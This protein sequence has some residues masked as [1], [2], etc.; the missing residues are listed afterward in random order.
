M[1]NVSK[2]DVHSFTSTSRF[3]HRFNT[4]IYKHR[5]SLYFLV[6]GI[7][8][9]VTFLGLKDS[10]MGKENPNTP[11]NNISTFSDPYGPIQ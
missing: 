10:G 9:F 4:T 7:S 6:T 2:P 1:P 8:A 5:M 3:G 11:I